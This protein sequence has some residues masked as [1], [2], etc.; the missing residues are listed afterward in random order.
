MA[1]IR[2]TAADEER[3][4]TGCSAPLPLSRRVRS[5]RRWCELVEASFRLL[6]PADLQKYNRKNGEGWWCASKLRKLVEKKMGPCGPF[7]YVPFMVCNLTFE[8]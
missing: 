8:F 5:A 4:G 3:R 1:M 7:Q 2:E 6:F